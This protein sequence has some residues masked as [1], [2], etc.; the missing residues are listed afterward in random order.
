MQEVF[1]K[2]CLT[3]TEDRKTQAESS[4]GE[5]W[6]GAGGI[7]LEE[8]TNKQ[9]VL[10]YHCIHIKISNTNL[11]CWQ[12][13]QKIWLVAHAASGKGHAVQPWKGCGHP[14]EG[15]G[16]CASEGR[17]QWNDTGGQADANVKQRQRQTIPFKFQ[18]NIVPSSYSKADL[19]CTLFQK[20]TITYQHHHKLCPL[21]EI[22]NL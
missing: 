11:W 1:I 17:S 18:L 8:Q 7:S 9:K 21:K 6:W 16:E 14:A 20:S 10:T 22:I 2:H 13:D 15:G 12:C 4:K 19:L 3:N 5:D